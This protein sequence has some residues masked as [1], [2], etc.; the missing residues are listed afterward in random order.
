MELLI[1][2]MGKTKNNSE[3]LAAM[4]GNGGGR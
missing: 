3:F 4:S 1:S 2:K